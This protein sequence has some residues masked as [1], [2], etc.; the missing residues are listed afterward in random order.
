MQKD[1]VHNII[2]SEIKCVMQWCAVISMLNWL[3]WRELL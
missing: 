3:Q 2:E 1:A